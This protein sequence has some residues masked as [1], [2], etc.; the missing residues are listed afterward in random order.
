MR[1][2]KV[3]ILYLILSLASVPFMEPAQSAS[4]W[5]EDWERVIQAAKKE[6]KVSVV[7][8]LA[9]E[10]REVLTQ[11]F[12]KRFG[13]VNGLRSGNTAKISDRIDV[14]SDHVAPWRMPIAG[15]VKTYTRDAM[16]AKEAR[17]CRVRRE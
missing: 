3:A 11:Q 7:G 2:I 4:S 6:G 12:E 9:R 14:P 15:S 5:Q 13:K 16:S 10:V 1:L 17:Y 8:F